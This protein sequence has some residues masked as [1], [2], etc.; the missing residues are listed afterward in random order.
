MRDSLPTTWLD[1]G[2]ALLGGAA[3]GV[4]FFGWLWLTVR[5]IVGAEGGLAILVASYLGRCAVLFLGLW[6]IG[7]GD[8]IRLL[9]AGGAIIA[10]RSLGVWAPF[11]S[12]QVTVNANEAD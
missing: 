4:V 7:Q 3:L 5:H 12:L 8:P 11:A 10:I 2:I 6:W 1:L 9:A